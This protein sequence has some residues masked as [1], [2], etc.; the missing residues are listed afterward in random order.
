M[1]LRFLKN[2]KSFHKSRRSQIQQMKSIPKTN[3]SLNFY[4]LPT[5][6]MFDRKANTTSGPATLGGSRGDHAPPPH[7]PT[8]FFC[9]CVCSKRKRETK[10]KK[11]QFQSRNYQN[12][13]TKVKM[14]LFQLF[15]SVQNS[16]TFLVGQPWW[17]SIHFSVPCPLH[18][19]IHFAGPELYK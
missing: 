2:F 8:L 18:F 6:A 14:L 12:T 17:P 5:S 13:V 11:K 7:H 10:E 3:I 1:L 15:Q 4:H 19:E 16:K 9:V